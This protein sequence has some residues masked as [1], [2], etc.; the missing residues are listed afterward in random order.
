M[1]GA[2]T[3]PSSQLYGR[4]E[5]S[6]YWPQGLHGPQQ[7]HSLNSHQLQSHSAKVVSCGPHGAMQVQRRCALSW[8][9]SA[10][11]TQW[12]P[13]SEREDREFHSEQTSHKMLI[14][15]ELGSK[16]YRT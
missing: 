1:P 15:A 12:R 13:E 3:A 11:V 7:P 4:A 8:A 16:C 10:E 2:P 5:Y 9:K 6:S 14:L